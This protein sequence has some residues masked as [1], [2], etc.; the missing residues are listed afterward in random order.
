MANIERIPI[1]GYNGKY[2]ITRNGEI[3]NHKLNRVLNHN[4]NGRGYKIVCLNRKNCYVHRL[5]AQTFLPNPQNKTEVNHINGNRS[6]NRLENLEWATPSENITHA[7]VT[8]NNKKRKLDT[9][10]VTYIRA[11]ASAYTQ[12]QLAAL[13]KVSITAIGLILKNETYK[14]VEL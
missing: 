10:A 4:D 8:G 7:T 2:T 5:M 1:D 6:D 14:E 3:V 9:E 12:K 11:N 13:F